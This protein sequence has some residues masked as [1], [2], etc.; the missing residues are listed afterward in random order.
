MNSRS[1][2]PLLAVGLYVNLYLV[3]SELKIL[4]EWNSDTGGSASLYG[5]APIHGQVTWYCPIFAHIPRFILNG[6]CQLHVRQR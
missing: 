6:P 3:I 4:W 2:V 5:L 1:S